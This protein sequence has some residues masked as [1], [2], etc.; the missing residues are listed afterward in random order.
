MSS[1]PNATIGEAVRIVTLDELHREEGAHD[2]TKEKLRQAE[3][4]AAALEEEVGRLTL[5]LGRAR[6][7]I[8]K[9]LA[10]QG[11]AVKEALAAKAN[12]VA[13]ARELSLSIDE[14][15]RLGN[16]LDRQREKQRRA[17]KVTRETAKVSEHD[18][19]AA[20]HAMACESLSPDAMT[21]LERV[22]GILASTRHIDGPWRLRAEPATKVEA[23]QA[24]TDAPAIAPNPGG[25][26]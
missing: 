10:D 22:F 4:K 19:L 20:V 5:N 2:D 7:E 23:Q 15:A 1:T 3:A 6:Q 9:A 14:R 11:G 12:M 17:W 25:A 24:A 26:A 21:D 13:L 8:V 16:E 18:T